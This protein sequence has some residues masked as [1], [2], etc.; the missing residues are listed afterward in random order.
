MAFRLPPD[1]IVG[2]EML[3]LLQEQMT[4]AK[5]AALDRRHSAVERARQAR[6]ACKKLRATLELVHCHAPTRFKREDRCFRDA[7]RSLAP[8]RDE[9]AIFI[10]LVDVQR[11]STTP[12]PFDGETFRRIRKT[13]RARLRSGVSAPA[14]SV[15]RSFSQEMVKAGARFDPIKLKR[16]KHDDFACIAAGFRRS[17][18]RARTAFRKANASSDIEALH[19]W[20]KRTKTHLNQCR[21]LELTC[22][23]MM[24][25]RVRELKRLTRLLGEEHDLA[26]LH[27]RI[28]AKT[29]APP[30]QPT[31]DLIL[32]LISDRVADLRTKALAKG[33]LIFW[34]KPR[35]VVTRVNADWKATRL[36][37]PHRTSRI[38][39]SRAC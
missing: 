34:E 31:A 18:T 30:D 20:R 38:T 10:A 39:R 7:A 28:N 9:G 23:R 4:R 21:L 2:K 26:V 25:P 22:P 27:E 14:E 29:F 33:Q 36:S 32:Q 15:L 24:P 3:R 19:T 5:R 16:S 35:A 8:I 13:L 6:V 17:Y 11:S 37:R 1:R 12:A